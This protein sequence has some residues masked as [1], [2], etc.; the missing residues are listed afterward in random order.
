M[1]IRMCMHVHVCMSAPTSPVCVPV[2]ASVHVHTCVCVCVYDK[3]NTIYVL[4]LFH[5]EKALWFEIFSLI[6]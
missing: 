5:G 6:S 1:C 2:C 4:L 3:Y